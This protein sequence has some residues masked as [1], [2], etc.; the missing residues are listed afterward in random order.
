MIER[1][2]QMNGAGWNYKYPDDYCTDMEKERFKRAEEC[3]S[4]D[5]K[6]NLSDNYVP[7]WL[8]CSCS[9][10]LGTSITGH[11]QLIQLGMCLIWEGSESVKKFQDEIKNELKGIRKKE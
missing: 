9:D 10:P 3:P 7:L 2:R 5:A 1:V 11:C 8:R 4:F 6:V